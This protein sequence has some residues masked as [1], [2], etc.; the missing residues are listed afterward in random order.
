MIPL[1]FFQWKY[2]DREMISININD[3]M[4]TPIWRRASLLEKHFSAR[5]DT[6]ALFTTDKDN[7][8]KRKGHAHIL[9][10]G[11]RNRRV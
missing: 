7:P 4:R 8:T 11:I 9:L 10:K 1:I 5:K 6:L 2:E 3:Q